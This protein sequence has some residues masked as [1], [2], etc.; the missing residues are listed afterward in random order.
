[1]FSSDNW[2]V[3]LNFF[4]FLNTGCGEFPS[5]PPMIDAANGFDPLLNLKILTHNWV[6]FREVFVFGLLLIVHTLCVS[7]QSTYL[8]TTSPRMFF[9]FQDTFCVSTNSENVSKSLQ[10]D[11][12]S[13]ITWRAG[14]LWTLS[15]KMWP[16]RM[17]LKLS[18]FNRVCT[19]P[20]S[21]LLTFQQKCDRRGAMNDLLDT[22][23]DIFGVNISYKIIFECLQHQILSC[24]VSN[25]R[26][27]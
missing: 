25:C 10:N 26:I 20:V 17:T 9:L 24:R 14:G 23:L 19:F 16:T 21:G 4:A 15:A 7:N 11:L 13:A 5:P 18:T 22:Y 27:W 6:F 12:L 2:T 1:M 8:S 3:H